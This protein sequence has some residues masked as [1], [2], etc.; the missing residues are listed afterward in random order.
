MKK[1]NMLVGSLLAAFVIS[2][3]GNVTPNDDVIIVIPED[4]FYIVDDARVGVAGIPYDCGDFYGETDEYGGF[5]FNP[6]NFNCVFDF[7]GYTM[8]VYIEDEVSPVN[9]IPYICQPSGIGGQ[10]GDSYAPGWMNYDYE[11]VCRIGFDI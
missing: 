2:G 8:D 1:F 5:S 6:D 3:C 11:D 4:V 9:G 10:T 7:I